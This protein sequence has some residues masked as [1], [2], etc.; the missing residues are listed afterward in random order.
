MGLIGRSKK[1]TVY[2]FFPKSEYGNKNHH[3]RYAIAKVQTIIAS[4]RP[5]GGCV[6]KNTP[7]MMPKTITVAPSL[8]LGSASHISNGSG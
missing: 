2:S 8:K 4:T 7:E 5:E 1:N 6:I 3:S